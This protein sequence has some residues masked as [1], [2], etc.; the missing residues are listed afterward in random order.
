MSTLLELKFLQSPIWTTHFIIQQYGFHNVAT[1][2][3]NNKTMISLQ[4]EAY[5]EFSIMLIISSD[6]D[7]NVIHILKIYST[8]TKHYV[9]FMSNQIYI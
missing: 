3:V 1:I 5:Y 4:L 8:M 9:E 2:Y 7:V 6:K